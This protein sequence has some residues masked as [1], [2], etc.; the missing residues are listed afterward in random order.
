MHDRDL[1]QHVVEFDGQKYT[2]GDDGHVSGPRRFEPQAAAFD[3]QKDGVEQ[4]GIGHQKDAV[5]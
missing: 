3:E 4:A 5:G 1:P 2:G